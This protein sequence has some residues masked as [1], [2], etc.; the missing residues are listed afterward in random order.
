[1]RMSVDDSN[2]SK[3]QVTLKIV[4]YFLATVN[5]AE[6]KPESEFKQWRSVKT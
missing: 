6:V 4:L 1:M 2:N 3:I 5:G